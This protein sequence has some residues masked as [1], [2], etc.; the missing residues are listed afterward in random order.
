[1]L[2]CVLVLIVFC[3]TEHWINTRIVTSTDGDVSPAENNWHV[4]RKISVKIWRSGEVFFFYFY[5][6][7]MAIPNV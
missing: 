4:K 6:E 1:M 7:L 3:G 2:I 5:F